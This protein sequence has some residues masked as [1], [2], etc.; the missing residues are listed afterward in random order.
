MN[1]V[2]TL[3]YLSKKFYEDYNNKDYPEIETKSNRPYMVLLIQ[4]D[5]N[6]FAIPFRTNIR[7][8]YCYKFK[9]SNR[10][11]DSVTGLD[12]TKA[13]IVNCSEYIGEETTIDNKEY[14]ELSNK[15]HFIIGKFKKYLDGYICYLNGNSTE[16]NDKKY[17]FTTLKYFQDALL[18]SREYIELDAV[19][20][21]AD[22]RSMAVIKIDTEKENENINKV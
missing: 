17:K 16:F 14:I 5:D 6:I 19:L 10:P 13:V 15:Y 7:H 11:T 4:I 2:F 21:D 1:T 9:N 12:F 3:N 20:K 18:H 22:S 8:R